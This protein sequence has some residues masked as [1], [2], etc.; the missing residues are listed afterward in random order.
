MTRIIV[1]RKDNHIVKVE[2]EGHTD[3]A[4]KGEDIVCAALSSIVQTALLGIMR[5]AGIRAEYV[6]E[7]E[8][9]LMQIQLPELNPKD[10]NNADMILETML[11]GIEDLYLGYSDFIELEV[12]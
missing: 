7:D 9:G 12:K 6:R 2:C 5:V 11:A 8:A 4:D 3:Y 1:T 10:R